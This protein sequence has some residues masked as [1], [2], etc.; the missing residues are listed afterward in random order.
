MRRVAASL[1][2]RPR[3][4]RLHLAHVLNDEHRQLVGVFVS[5]A[6]HAQRR[7]A[8]LEALMRLRRSLPSSMDAEPGGPALAM[9]KFSTAGKGVPLK[10]LAR[11]ALVG[12][13]RSCCGQSAELR[14]PSGNGWG[15][16][17]TSTGDWS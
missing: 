4:A 3:P 9:V 14:E 15:S 1:H 13:I 5:L 8:Q 17:R 2:R 10:Q 11:P 16:S 12:M 7:R 6:N